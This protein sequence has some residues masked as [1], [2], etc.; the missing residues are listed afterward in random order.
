MQLLS[1]SEE[2][3]IFRKAALLIKK[4]FTKGMFARNANQET[5]SPTNSN[6]CS[7]CAVGAIRSAAGLY[8]V[9]PLL[10]Y[11]EEELQRTK[12]HV[13]GYLAEWNDKPERTKEDVI[14]F[15]RNC[16]KRLKNKAK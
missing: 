2:A 3:A 14:T 4:G 7:F 8:T 5:V 6:A 9:G 16:A 13:T 15:L 1:I 10:D 11:A 12:K